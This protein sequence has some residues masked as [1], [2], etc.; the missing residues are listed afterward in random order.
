MEKT[1]LIQY[2]KPIDSQTENRIKSAFGTWLSYFGQ[3]FIVAT[4]LT[5]KQIYEAVD[6]GEEASIFIVELNTANYYG[7]MNTKVWDWLKNRNK[8]KS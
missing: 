6:L 4:E 7:R 5:P 1:Y 2:K 8:K 3:N